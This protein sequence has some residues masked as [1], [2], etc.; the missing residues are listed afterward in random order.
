MQ[1]EWGK[2]EPLSRQRYETYT[3]LLKSRKYCIL[4]WLYSSV[5]ALCGPWPLFQFLNLYTVSRTH[6]TSDKPVA[7]P[8]PTHTTTQ[9]HNKRT[10]THWV[11]FEPTM[12]AFG[13]T[14]T[15]HALDRAVTAIGRNYCHRFVIARLTAS[16]KRSLVCTIRYQLHAVNMASALQRSFFFLKF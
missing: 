7:K 15:V 8:L 11:G 9:T 16:F 2:P 14:E 12:S 5:W 10:S 13:R 1:R 3:S 6:W 4:L